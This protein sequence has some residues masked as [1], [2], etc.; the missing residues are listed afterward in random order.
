[1]TPSLPP[2][3]VWLAHAAEVLGRAGRHRSA[4]R[5]KLIRALAEQSC[6][7]SAQELEAQMRDRHPNER[8]VARATVYRTLELLHEHRLVNRLDLGDGIARHEIVDPG[9][10]ERHHHHFVCARCGELYPFDDPALERSIGELS[11]RHGFS[12]TDHEVTLRG[13]CPDCD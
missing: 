6:A 9:D 7:L 8:P 3:Q 12:V 1:M 4:A 11:A 2:T 5:E 10:A 13:V